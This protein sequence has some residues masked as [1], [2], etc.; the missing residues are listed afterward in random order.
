VPATSLRFDGRCATKRR[1]KTVVSEWL[2]NSKEPVSYRWLFRYLNADRYGDVFA[3]IIQELIDQGKVRKSLITG[4][5]RPAHILHWI[6]EE[7][8][9]GSLGVDAEKPELTDMAVKGAVRAI[10][11]THV[12]SMSF[13]KIGWY[14][15]ARY[16]FATGDLDRQL[17][18]LVAEKYLLV[19]QIWT[20]EKEPT[21][22]YTWNDERQTSA[23]A[24]ERF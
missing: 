11:A 22:N 24:Q 21:L 4:K 18:Q 16:M 17:A 9:G 12:G 1:L 14:L 3:T 7:K 15:K 23:E 10:M 8:E 2:R 13:K 19:Q 6:S 20:R 5:G